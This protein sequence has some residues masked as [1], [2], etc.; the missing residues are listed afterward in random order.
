MDKWSDKA[1]GSIGDIY[2]D[3]WTDNGHYGLPQGDSA[4]LPHSFN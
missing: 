4:H 3:I 2:D 1:Y